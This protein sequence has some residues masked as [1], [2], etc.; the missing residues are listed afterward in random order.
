MTYQEEINALRDKISK[1]NEGLRA[2]LKAQ[3]QRMD[4][5]KDKQL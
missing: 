3:K 1:Y 4:F 2:R 5:Y